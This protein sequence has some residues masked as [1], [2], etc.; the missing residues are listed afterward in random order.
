MLSFNIS[1]VFDMLLDVPS[2]HLLTDL[3]VV[4]LVLLE[5]HRPIRLGVHVLQQSAHAPLEFKSMP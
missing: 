2:T 5:L 3:P 1:S 4:P